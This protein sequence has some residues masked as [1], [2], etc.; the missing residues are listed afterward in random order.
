MPPWSD[1]CFFRNCRGK[2]EE[3]YENSF[4]RFLFVGALGTVVNILIFFILADTLHFDATFSSVVAFLFAVTQNYILNHVWSFKN[5][6]NFQ[7][8]RKSYFK[9]VCVNIF[10]LLINLLVLNLILLWFNPAI[11]TEAQLFGVLSGTL[12]NFILSRMYV[13]KKN[14]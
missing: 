12:F 8:N 3:L 11:K 4:L 6:V 5:I 9:Y 10:G 13:F 7:V 2:I 1:N 14:P